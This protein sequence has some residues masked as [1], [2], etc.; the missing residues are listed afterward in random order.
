MRMN[1]VFRD[2][3]DAKNLLAAFIINVGDAKKKK[4]TVA[5]K[6]VESCV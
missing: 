4:L 2:L 5:S 1:G 3:I 6:Q